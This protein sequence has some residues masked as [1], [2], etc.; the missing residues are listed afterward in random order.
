MD[1]DC[2]FASE[3]Y[4]E[5]GMPSLG[6]FQPVE[7]LFVELAR[8]AARQPRRPTSVPELTRDF[9]LQDL[10]TVQRGKCPPP[11]K[12][13]DRGDIP[14]VTASERSNGIAGYYD[15]PRDKIKEHGSIR[16]LYAL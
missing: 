2:D 15:V 4:L 8:R 6:T 9:E 1:L 7:G 3:A 13:L 14:V 10:F 12:N 16:D 5:S 11:L